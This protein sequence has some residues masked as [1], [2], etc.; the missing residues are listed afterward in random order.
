MGEG[1]GYFS[2]FRSATDLEKKREPFV[3]THLWNCG[4]CNLI[5]NF[6]TSI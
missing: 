5:P 3:G 6:L 4:R 1:M 2:T